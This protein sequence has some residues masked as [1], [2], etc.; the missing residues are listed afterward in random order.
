[1]QKELIAKKTGLTP[2]VYPMK[3]R[4]GD[5]MKRLL[6]AG[7]AV[8]LALYL[9]GCGD[10]DDRRIFFGEILSDQP[11]DGDIAFD[12]IQDLYT[13]TNGPDTLFFGIDEADRNLPEYRAFLDFPLDGSAGDRIP[14]DAEIQWATLEVYIDEVSFAGVI[15][16]LLELVQFPVTGLTPED[17]DS[18][19][20]QFPDGGDASIEFD[21]FS[22][23]EDDFVTLDVTYLM[24]EVQRRGLSDFQVRFV[25]D[26]DSDIGL[27]GIEDRPSVAVT[28]PLLT[29]RFR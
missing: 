5:L 9:S 7:I 10:G 8:V 16:T 17:F 22:S 27:V 28:A 26:F 25:L 18:F 12:P 20:L 29:V 19:P 24:R 3:N 11:V 4:R 1:M 21:F 2:V 13:I 14:L 23:D 15:P 6:F